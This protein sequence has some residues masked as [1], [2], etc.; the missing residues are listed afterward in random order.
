M[1]LLIFLCDVSKIQNTEQKL[2]KLLYHRQKIG[3]YRNIIRTPTT[4]TT[5]LEPENMSHC[6]R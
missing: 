5:L 1:K 6:R 2:L 4:R 3:I